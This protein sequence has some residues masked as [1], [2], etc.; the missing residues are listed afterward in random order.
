MAVRPPPDSIVWKKSAFFPTVWKSSEKGSVLSI[1]FFPFSPSSRL[2][3]CRLR[4]CA[5]HRILRPG[6]GHRLGPVPEGARAR[7]RHG[8]HRLPP[9]LFEKPR[10]GRLGQTDGPRSFRRHRIRNRP[11][12]SPPRG[13]PPIRHLLQERAGLVH[14]Q[15]AHARRRPADPGVQQV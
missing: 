8:R 12:L 10:P 11:G 9:A 5:R 4:I 2:V 15:Q 14:G 3:P 13:H 6:H 7:L 1:N